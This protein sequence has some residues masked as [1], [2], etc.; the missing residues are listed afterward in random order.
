MLVEEG[1]AV[2]LIAEELGGEA[3]RISYVAGAAE[4]VGVVEVEVALRLGFGVAIGV[5]G[6][7][8]VGVGG[9]I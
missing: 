3:F 1:R 2:G 8:V 9:L 7:G 6:S 4:V 5:A